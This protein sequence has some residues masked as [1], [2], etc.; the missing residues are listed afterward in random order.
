MS[1]DLP[2]FKNPPLVEAAVS[3]QFEPLRGFSNAH[4][5]LFWDQLRQSYP[6]SVDAG[7]IQPQFERFGKDV[8][9]KPR[10]PKFRIGPADTVARLQMISEDDQT[11]VQVQN[12]R[13]AFNWRR[14]TDGE[15][16]RWHKVYPLFKEAFDEFA[17]FLSAQGLGA[18]E[19]NQWEVAYVNHLLRERDWSGPADWP[20]LLPGLVGTGTRVSSGVQESVGGHMRFVLPEEA[21]RLHVEMF[22]GFTSA[23]EDTPEMLGLQLTARGPVDPENVDSLFEGLELGHRAIVHTF[24]EITGPEAH[25]RWERE[26]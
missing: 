15:Y 17:S 19:P 26:Q 1:K 11:M 18:V 7:P 20:N 6:K 24:A 9:R 12:G 5:G 14:A 21:G 23:E 16:P 10:L 4:L 13:L 25:E 2:S 3:V 8:R 22:H